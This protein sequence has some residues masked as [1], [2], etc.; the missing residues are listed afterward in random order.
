MENLVQENPQRLVVGEGLH[1]GR[2]VV[3]G[4][5]IGGHG[6]YL[7]GLPQGGMQEE[8][9]EEGVV[10]QEAQAQAVEAFPYHKLPHP[11]FS[12]ANRK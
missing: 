1:K 6:G 11:V 12:V 8:G 4:V 3:N 10:G 7:K 9:A 2:V 5:A